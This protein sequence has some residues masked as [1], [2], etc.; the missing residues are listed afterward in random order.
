MLKTI[1]AVV[2]VLGLGVLAG[3][4][5]LAATLGHDYQVSGVEEGDML[6]LRAG[7]GT[8][9]QILAGLPNGTALRVESCQQTGGTRWCKVTSP[10]SRG[11]NGY[12]SWA[13]LSEI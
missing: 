1:T 5:P 4:A 8:G 10:Q 3:C 12:V 13:Y 6:K 2:T 9:F 7:P 11:L